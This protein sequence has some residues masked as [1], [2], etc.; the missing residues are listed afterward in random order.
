[1]DDENR[2]PAARRRGIRAPPARAL[3]ALVETLVPE[4]GSLPGAAAVQAGARAVEIL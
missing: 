2:R 4:G 1:M 3:R